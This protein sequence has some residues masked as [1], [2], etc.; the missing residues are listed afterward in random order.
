MQELFV[1][2]VKFCGV[3]KINPVFILLAKIAIFAGV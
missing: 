3:E 1:E 2:Q